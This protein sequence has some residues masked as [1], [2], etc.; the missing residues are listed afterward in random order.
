MSAF[1]MA[2]EAQPKLTESPKC[3]KCKKETLEAFELIEMRKVDIPVECVLKVV[4][5]H[6]GMVIKCK[7]CGR[8]I[9]YLVKYRDVIEPELIG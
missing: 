7:N 9:K 1:V 2:K 6:H 3:P 8:G 5:I 4:P